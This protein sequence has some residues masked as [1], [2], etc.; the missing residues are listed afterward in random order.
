MATKVCGRWVPMHWRQ[1]SL[2]GVEPEPRFFK[3]AT[4]GGRPRGILLRWRGRWH[5]FGILDRHFR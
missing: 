5:G 3:V 2:K 1:S 4:Q